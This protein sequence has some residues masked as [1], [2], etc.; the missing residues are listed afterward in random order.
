MLQ[1][2]LDKNAK[3]VFGIVTEKTTVLKK[4]IQNKFFSTYL[5]YINVGTLLLSIYIFFYS[6]LHQVDAE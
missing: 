5:H 1:E 4:K 2:M 6:C 3:K